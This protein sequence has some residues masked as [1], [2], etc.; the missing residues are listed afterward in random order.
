MLSGLCVSHLEVIALLQG[1]R[2]LQGLEVVSTPLSQ[3]VTARCSLHKK[4]RRISE[5]HERW[6]RSCAARSWGDGEES[7]EW[8]VDEGCREMNGTESDCVFYSIYTHLQ[9]CGQG[10]ARGE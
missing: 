9:E 6:G 5:E 3:P 2:S 1:M 4:E 10:G 7:G 8:G